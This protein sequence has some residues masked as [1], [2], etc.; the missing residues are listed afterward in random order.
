[1]GLNTGPAVIGNM[2]SRTRFSYTMMGDNVNLAARMESGAK[3]LGVYTMVTDA[4]KL[5][6]KKYGGERIVFRLLDKIIVKGRG[7]PLAVFEIVGLRE[8]VPPATLQCLALYAQALELYF[9]EDWDGAA[10][11][12]EQSLVL[13]PNQV[14]PERGIENNPSSIFIQRCRRLKFMRQHSTDSQWDGVFELKDK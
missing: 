5:A 12:F 10:Q 8:N 7:Q 14:S 2:G 6:C 4:T 9:R 3:A 1:M 13:E 11:I